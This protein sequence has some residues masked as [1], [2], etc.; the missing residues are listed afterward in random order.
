MDINNFVQES[1]IWQI[2][3]NPKTLIPLYL[4]VLP[5][6]LIVVSHSVWCFLLYYLPLWLLGTLLALHKETLEH[7]MHVEAWKANT[8]LGLN[9]PLHPSLRKQVLTCHERHGTEPNYFS[10]PA[11]AILETSILCWHLDIWESPAKIN[12]LTAYSQV[13]LD[14]WE[15]N[16]CC[17]T[18][19]WLYIW[20]I[21]NIISANVDQ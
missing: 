16:T 11:K 2:L 3:I 8:D 13:K 10:H 18:S 19:W 6:I 1:T 21:W 14:I 7:T 5:Y 12:N 4:P 17:S 9:F 15:I 20:L